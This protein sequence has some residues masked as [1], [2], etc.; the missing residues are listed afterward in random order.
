MTK[1]PSAPLDF[2]QSLERW[3]KDARPDCLFEGGGR[4]SYLRWRRRFLRHYLRCLGPFP[5]RV[6][7]KA[8]LVK[9][10]KEKGYTREHW[11]YDSSPGIS[12]PAILLIP[13]GLREPAP[14][15]LAAHGHGGGK[16]D[17]CGLPHPVWGKK[18]AAWTRTLDYDYA[19]QA[20]LR[21]YVVLAP[22]FAPFGERRPPE[23]WLRDD[24]DACDIVDLCARYFGFNLLSLNLWDAMRG[25]DLLAAHPKVDPRRMGVIGLSYGGTLAA[26]LMVLD[27]RLKAGVVSGY[28]STLLG[29]AFGM[30][31]KGNTCGA[32]A[33]PWLLRHGD[34]PEIFGLVAPKP[35]L[36]EI[37]KEE[38]CFES[39]DML[40]ASARVARIYRAAGVGKN[41][42]KDVFAGGHRWNGVKA[43]PWLAAQLGRGQPAA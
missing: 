9:R 2:F 5:A 36:L 37:G 27:R 43:W 26:H 18:H 8:R 3:S 40:K 19:R 35:L 29:D 39:G 20:V 4:A 6:P 12:V 7:L 23:I 15:L 38:D 10:V 14:A 25:L 1:K 31:G 34:I 30:R 28:V 33:L 11:I 41:L 22:D 42:K 16:T 17:V 21:G 24:R 13:D 32:Q